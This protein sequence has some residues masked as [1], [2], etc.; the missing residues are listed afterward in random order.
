MI[1]LDIVVAVLCATV[2]TGTLVLVWLFRQQPQGS[3]ALGLYLWWQ[4]LAWSTLV[5]LQS[6]GVVTATPV[7]LPAWLTPVQLLQ[8]RTLPFLLLMAYT[9]WRLLR[10]LLHRSP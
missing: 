8:A 9:T 4:C 2:W 7:W 3:P 6:V 10:D 5:L 1:L